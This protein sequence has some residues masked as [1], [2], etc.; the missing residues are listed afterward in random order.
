MTNLVISR[1]TSSQTEEEEK[2]K[3][4]QIHRVPDIHDKILEKQKNTKWNQEKTG[5]SWI[6]LLKNGKKHE[7]MET[8]TGRIWKILE[9]IGRNGKKQKET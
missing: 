3:K 9:E 7:E 5:K 4:I 1:K 2:K 8:K 6:F